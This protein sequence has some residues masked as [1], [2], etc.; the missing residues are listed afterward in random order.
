MPQMGIHL[1]V[2]ILGSN[3]KIFKYENIGIGFLIGNIIP[4]LDFLILI[5]LRLINRELSLLFHRS[6]SHSL[7]FI[8]LLSIILI[9][10]SILKHKNIVYIFLG[11]II[12]IFTHITLDIVFWF[13]HVDILWPLPLT[14]NLYSNWSLPA[15][16]PNIVSSFEPICYGLF[17]F[18][19]RKKLNLLNNKYINMIIL[20][21]TVLSII[22][23][24]F[25]FI[26][27]IETFEI[28]SYGIAIS[29]GF[30]SSIYYLIKF[31]RK[32]FNNEN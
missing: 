28:I 16:T 26:L 19:I 6:F 4:D 15:Y 11:L 12:G 23:I 31:R 3:K 21:L 24:P 18:L 30:I 1:C 7:F 13:Y 8:L 2:G 10:Y 29:L 9:I 25:A 5:P 27:D 22:L 32:F 20:T 14:L 17:L